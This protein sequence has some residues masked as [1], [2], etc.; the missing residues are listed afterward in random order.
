MNHFKCKLS[1]QYLHFN[2]KEIKLF[3]HFKIYH[4]IE[5]AYLLNTLGS[6]II[7]FNQNLWLLYF[8]LI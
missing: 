4:F 3:I 6:I 2:K 1:S 8:N 5:T 7:I